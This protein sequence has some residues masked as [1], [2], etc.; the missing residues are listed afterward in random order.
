MDDGTVMMATGGRR[1]APFISKLYDI[2]TRHPEMC[3]FGESGDSLVV[4][5]EKKLEELVL[6]QYFRHGNYRSFVRQLNL[7]EFKKDANR[8]LIIYR[9]PHFLRGRPDL[10]HLMERQT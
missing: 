8:T 5:D 10:L 3:G 1:V 9:H 2:A 6:P 7:Y 4:H